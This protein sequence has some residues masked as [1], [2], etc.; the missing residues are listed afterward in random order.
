KTNVPFE[1]E[2]FKFLMNIFLKIGMTIFL[3]QILSAAGITFA[4]NPE[5]DSLDINNIQKKQEHFYDSLK[6]RA[7]Q[8]RL[9]K[10]V[11]D[12]LVNSPRPYV[13]KKA[14][15]IDYYSPFEGKII[16]EIKIKPLDIF[17][18]TFQDTAKKASSW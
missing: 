12:F 3:L 9:T 5:K 14:A 16:S 6:Y 1:V 15:T 17:G 11:Y 2:S 18:P 13:D 10:L 4:Q 8:K 7:S